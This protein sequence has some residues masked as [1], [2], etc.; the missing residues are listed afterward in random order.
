MNSPTTPLQWF[1]YD[2]ARAHAGVAQDAGN[3]VR[4][5]IPPTIVTA[6]LLRDGE[7]RQAHPDHG[8]DASAARRSTARRRCCLYGYGSYGISMDA[9]FSIRRLQL[10]RSRLDLRHRACARRFGDGLRLVPGW[11]ALQQEEHLHA[12]SSPCAEELI[13]A[14]LR[15][16]RQ[17]RLR[18]P[19]G[20]RLADGR[21]QQH[22]ARSVGRR[23]RRR[24]VHRCAQHDERHLAAADAAGMARMGQSA[25]GRGRRT[26][27]S[28]PI[29]PTPTSTRKRI[30]R[31]SRPAGSPIRA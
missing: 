3:S 12:I 23:D 17:H 21:D 13:G 15:P 7:R 26:T 8:A 10:G 28:R 20:R 27:T 31:C 29:A 14:R 24:A 6:A 11:A 30:R 22:A 2:M 16:R 19:L 1:D 5:T 4:A 18:R 9:D 25:R